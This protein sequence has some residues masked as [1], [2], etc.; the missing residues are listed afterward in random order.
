M[1]MV[2]TLAAVRCCFNSS[3]SVAHAAVPVKIARVPL[4]IGSNISTGVVETAEEDDDEE[5]YDRDG[6][7]ENQIVV[8]D[9]NNKWRTSIN[10]HSGGGKRGGGE[11]NGNLFYLFCLFFHWIIVLFYATSYY[12]FLLVSI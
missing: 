11:V 8:A 12:R 7:F 4:S 2:S 1:D 10:E 9:T 6:W 5:K 3:S